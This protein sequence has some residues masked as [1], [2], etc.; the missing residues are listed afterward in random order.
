MKAL[1]IAA[2]IAGAAVAVAHSAPTA[3]VCTEV[4]VDALQGFDMTGKP[5]LYE[6][7]ILRRMV[8]AET[9]DSLDFFAVESNEPVWEHMRDL[10]CGI[11]E[12]TPGP[13]PVIVEDLTQ[14]EDG[15]TWRV[16]H[17]GAWWY[18]GASK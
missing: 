7:Q 1:L 10:L 17:D 4:T 6:G 9:G 2:M 15:L 18:G 12:L 3:R 5:R 16:Q 14:S 8:T 13:S 11:T